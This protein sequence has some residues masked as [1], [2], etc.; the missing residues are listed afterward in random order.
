MH[1]HGDNRPDKTRFTTE[2]AARREAT[3]RNADSRA[4]TPPT[5]EEVD[6]AIWTCIT[7]G[8]NHG[9]LIATHA[10]PHEDV[11][12]AFDAIKD[13]EAKLKRLLASRVSASSREPAADTERLDWLDENVD[14]ADDETWCEWI[15]R[16]RAARSIDAPTEERNDG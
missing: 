9:V 2:G 11:G 15:D 6:A 1:R 5:E 13:A 10:S 7:A 14:C 12:K 16:K 8:E 4:P 3:R